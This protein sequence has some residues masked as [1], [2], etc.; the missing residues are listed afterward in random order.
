MF[1]AIFFV[2]IGMMGSSILISNFSVIIIISITLIVG[3]MVGNT[4]GP[5]FLV[6]KLE[7]HL[8]VGMGLAQIGEF[9]FIIAALG[10]SLKVTVISSTYPQIL[11]N[12]YVNYAVSN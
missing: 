6:K 10:A 9:S 11:G 8:K 3:K 2:T 5:L 4:I 1:C 12:Y 7:H